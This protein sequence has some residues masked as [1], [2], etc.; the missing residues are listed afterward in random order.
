VKHADALAILGLVGC[1]LSP[2][3]IATAF[4]RAVVTAH[5]DTGG[6][7]TDLSPL[8]EAKRVLLNRRN[9]S[10]FACKQCSG[11]GTV[12]AR[13]GVRPCGACKG[14]GETVGGH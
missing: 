11:R 14:T 7:A 3:V 8:L 10:D 13:L 5:P 12:P 9:V 2:E 4:R 1:E 6:T